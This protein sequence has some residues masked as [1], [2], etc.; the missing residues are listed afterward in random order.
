MVEVTESTLAE[1][2]KSDYNEEVGFCFI[3]R[4]VEIY[5]E[6]RRFTGNAY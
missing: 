6:I 2:T 5:L 1:V 3:R 4:T